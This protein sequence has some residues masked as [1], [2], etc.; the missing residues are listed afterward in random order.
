MNHIGSGMQI[1]TGNT[2]K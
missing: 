1:I 2:G